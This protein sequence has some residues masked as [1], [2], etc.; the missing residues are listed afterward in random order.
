DRWNELAFA[1]GGADR[2]ANRADEWDAGL[3]WPDFA[4]AELGSLAYPSSPA[5]GRSVS[6]V[7]PVHVAF[8]ARE[9]LVAAR[10]TVLEAVAGRFKDGS[11]PSALTFVTGPSRSADI[12]MDLSIGVHGPGEVIAV[13]IEEA[14]ARPQ[15]VETEAG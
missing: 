13:L 12:E 4:V 5:Q 3:D 14:G 6:L 15:G 1:H 2:E 10:R 11:G 7:P 8:V 9:A